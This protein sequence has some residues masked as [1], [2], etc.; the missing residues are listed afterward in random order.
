MALLMAAS[1]AYA[2]LDL[3]AGTSA[4]TT[5]NVATAIT[6]FQIIG[7]AASTTPV[8][9]RATSGTLSMTTVSG[10]TFTGGQSG[11][12]VS[13][14]GAVANINAALATLKYTRA[15]TGSDTLEVSLVEP[16]EVFFEDNGHLYQYISDAGTWEAA[17]TKAELLT[18]YGAQGY[19]TTISSSAE[20]EFVADRLTN[21]GWMGASDAASEGVWRWVT[22]PEAGTQFWSG[23]IGGST[24]GGRYA[25]WSSGEPNDS[26]SN[27]DCAQ[28]LTGGTG[29]WNDLPCNSTSLPGYVAE[30]GT[31]GNLP[32]VVAR[33]ISIV[34]ADVPAITTLTPA[35][36]ASG[37][38]VDASL[39]IGF[40]KT[41]TKNTGNI[42]I[43]RYDD[44]SVVETISVAGDQV[45][46]SAST[47]AVITPSVT[48]EEG[49]RYYVTLPG[50]AF[51]DGSS[52]P[53]DG[54]STKSTWSFTTEDVTAP[55]ITNAT[56]S[57]ATTTATITWN[58]NEG[59]SSRV[60]YGPTSAYGA[61]TSITNTSPRVTSHSRSLT[62]LL[63]CTNYH[64]AV[65]STDSF[66][67]TATSSNSQFLTSGCITSTP[68]SSTH[69]ATVPNDATATTTLQDNGRTL[70]VTTPA[71]F[72][73]TSST[74]V[75]QI[76]AIDSEATLAVIGM[77]AARLESAAAVAFDVTALIDSTTV[78]DSFDA[79]V[80]ITYQYTDEDI[81]GLVESSLSM[82][83]YH[84]DAWV[85]LSD[86]TL[87]MAANTISCNTPNF[88]TFA[89]FGTLIPNATG[90]S[91]A[92]GTSVTARVKNLISLGN[93]AQAESLKKE[94][95]NLFPESSAAT[96]QESTGTV[97]V[98]DLEQG[99]EGADVR[100]LQILLNANG[101][102]LASS[103]VGSVG[104]ETEY[105]GSLTQKALAA[106]QA[107]KGVVPAI[108]YF[109]PITRASMTANAVTG[110]W[111]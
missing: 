47:T 16:G 50:S 99:M 75:I 22:G 66:N 78:L 32:T 56:S 107:A 67:N 88:S 37:V 57:A 95:P 86:C 77:P 89:I 6:G 5:P 2:A 60:V 10:L 74:V 35:N 38:A 52:N 69:A 93:T 46:A 91:R 39:S 4:T 19:L 33:N 13:F 111:W 30:F 1:P 108:G 34:T 45:T 84:D 62:G 28:F 9:L 87:D 59:A 105:F 92:R 26:S 55:V 64:F 90:S 7:P 102:P 31:D 21:A 100:M 80:T 54:V 14:S 68:P 27:E 44:D 104:N 79:P 36:G 85:E 51:L 65:V 15:S 70:T 98:R 83:H 29:M 25:N 20:N 23:A 18:R 17:K 96:R 43:H 101:Y 24:V 41:V 82:F 103:G 58:T 94:W 71:N 12:T 72:T 97:T 42:L 3:T 11:S 53:F 40:S 63:S 76:K 8:R 109:G 110:G 49:T 61:A 106:Y 73:A 81:A 48:L